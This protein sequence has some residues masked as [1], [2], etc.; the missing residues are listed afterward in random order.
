MDS[1]TSLDEEYNTGSPFVEL[2]NREGSVEILDLF[3]R[4]E[5]AWLT[6]GNVRALTGLD[7]GTVE[8]RLTEL[9]G[10]GIIR[11]NMHAMGRLYTLNR[12]SEA[13]AGLLQAHSVLLLDD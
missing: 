10:A 8:S 7:V 1:Q 11:L 9:C 12:D 2:L 4:K 6:Q 3:L 5:Y 13:V